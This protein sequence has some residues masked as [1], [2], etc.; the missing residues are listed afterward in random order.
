MTNIVRNTFFRS[1]SEPRERGVPIAQTA[2][3]FTRDCQLLVAF[4]AL[5][6]RGIAVGV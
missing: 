2:M 1:G 6:A 4:L 5:A 3:S